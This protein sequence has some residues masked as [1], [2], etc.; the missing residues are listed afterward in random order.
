M[1]PPL[2]NAKG[3]PVKVNFLDIFMPAPYRSGKG[4]P[5]Q[6]KKTVSETLIVNTHCHF[7]ILVPGSWICIAH[8]RSIL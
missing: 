1:A 4:G 8:G 5:R 7:T 2:L 6:D 3:Q